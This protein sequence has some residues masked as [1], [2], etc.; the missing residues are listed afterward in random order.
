MYLL[1]GRLNKIYAKITHWCATM[2]HGARIG[3]H[4]SA[5]LFSGSLYI[6]ESSTAA[7][8]SEFEIDVFEIDVLRTT[9]KS[10]AR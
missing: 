3:H 10:F 2:E 9:F 8:V 6:L 1:V 7:H 4:P 5:H